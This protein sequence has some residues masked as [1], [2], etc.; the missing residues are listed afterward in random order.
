MFLQDAED[1][2][3]L[4]VNLRRMY[5][6]QLAIRVSNEGLFADMLGLLDDFSNLDDEVCIFMKHNCVTSGFLL[7]VSVPC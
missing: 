7:M 2:Y 1:D 5:Q 6:L 4:T 3:S